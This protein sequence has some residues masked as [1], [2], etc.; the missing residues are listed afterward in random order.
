MNVP[1]PSLSIF[2]RA[3]NTRLNQAGKIVGVIAR[4]AFQPRITSLIHSG[5]V[6]EVDLASDQSFVYVVER[7]GLT[8]GGG[9]SVVAWSESDLA[10]E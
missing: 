4:D 9:T 3:K 10:V 7:E 5:L 2:V 1:Q 6:D 8:S